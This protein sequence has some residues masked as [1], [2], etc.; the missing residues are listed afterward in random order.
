M[1]VGP[2]RWQPQ[3]QTLELLRD[4]RRVVPFAGAGLG[5]PAGLPSGPGLAQ[6]LRTE[7]PLAAGKVFDVPNNLISVSSTL[8]QNPEARASVAEYIC[9]IL[10]I[11]K[12]GYTP[13]P[14]LDH[15]VRIPSRWYV[16]TTYD[17]LA[18]EAADGQGIAYESFTW[19]QLPAFEDLDRDADH[20]LYIVHLHGS[21]MEPDSL[22][23][24]AQSYHDIS[25]APDVQDF[26]HLL[27][28]EFHICFFGT[29]LDEQYLAGY[30]LS[31]KHTRPRHVLVGDETAIAGATEGRAPI[32]P[33]MHGVM[34]EAFPAGQ[35]ELLDEFCDSLVT[36]PATTDAPLVTSPPPTA[37]DAETATATLDLG[38]VRY[39]RSDWGPD[40]TRRAITELAA[41]NPE[42]A[43]KLQ[44]TLGQSDDRKLVGVLIREPEKWMLDGSFRL[45]V[46]VTRF[47]EQQGDW[48]LAREGWLQAAEREGADKVACLVAASVS[49]DIAGN[50]ETG[51]ALLDAARAID[52]THPRVRLQDAS[53]AEDGD[54]QLRALEELW[55]EDGD[56]GAI[57]H[58]QAAIAYLSRGEFDEAESHLQAARRV[59]VD[60]LQAR[61]V[62]AN[63][64]VHRNRVALAKGVQVDGR[65]LADVRVE[66]LALRDELKAMHRWGESVRLLMLAA[67]ATA[68]QWELEE[69]GRL[70]L[71]ATDEEKKVE[72]G[73]IVLADAALRA[74]QS[75]VALELLGPLPEGEV[76]AMRA[77]A[78]LDIGDPDV[79][80]RALKTLDELVAPGVEVEEVELYR[81]AMVR[82][83][84]ASQFPDAGWPEDAERVLDEQG[85]AEVALVS[86]AMWLHASGKPAEARALL[87]PHAQSLHV[88]ELLLQLAV[89]DQ[90]MQE[91]Q[92]RVTD[93]LALGPDNLTRLRCAAVLWDARDVSRAKA[94]AAAVAGDVTATP[95]ERGQAYNLLAGIAADAE[96][97]YEQALSFFE[98]WKREEPNNE[99]HVWGRV[100]A[101]TRLARHADAL[102]L[103]EQTRAYPQTMTDGRLAAMVYARM[104]DPVEALRR[105][106]EVIDRAPVHD[107]EIERQLQ[108]VALHR[109]SGIELP[110]ELAA[111]V[112]PKDLEAL[113]L[114]AV[115]FGTLREQALQ[116]QATQ[117]ELLRGI[118]DGEVST[119]ALAAVVGQDIGSL[120]MRLSLRPLGYGNS[121][122]DALDRR[123]AEAALSRG[124][125]LDPTALFTLGGLGGDIGEAG[126]TALSGRSRLAQASLDD[127]DHGRAALLAELPTMS[128]RELTFDPETGQPVSIEWPRELVEQ[129]HARA[130]E[131]LSM[132]R[133]FTVEP[134]FDLAHPAPTDALVDE[135]TSSALKSLV[136]TVSVAQRTGLPIYSDDRNVRLLVR[137][138]RIPT[139]GTLVLLHALQER[140]DL[141]EAAVT[142]A[143]QRLRESGY[144]GVTATQSELIELL[145]A[146]GGDAS[147][148]L[149]LAFYD[150][151]PWRGEYGIHI[152]RVVDFLR[153]VFVSYPSQFDVWVL[154]LLVAMDDGLQIR[155]PETNTIPTLPERLEWH[156][157]WL[158]VAA[159]LGVDVNGPSSH[160]FLKA[161]R[162]GLDHA[163]RS[164]D[165][166]IAPLP[167]AVARF[168]AVARHAGINHPSG[169][170]IGLL[171]Q[172]PIT[173]VMRIVGV[174]PEARFTPLPPRDTR[175][176]SPDVADSIQRINTKAD[177]SAEQRRRR[178]K[179]K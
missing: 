1:A 171:A 125:V 133:A 123:D 118:M 157:Q 91:A 50:T 93:V 67:D 164:L 126:M 38:H 148:A 44:E 112:R 103:L 88:A 51:R 35:F 24:D 25:Q 146:S 41:N 89:M 48:D 142:T 82:A 72:A 20:P 167:G 71:T 128:R 84:R 53:Q 5:I 29:A 61:I 34:T 135:A 79:K 85:H 23:L 37:A 30:L 121:D 21:V 101:L 155:R 110:E 90:D 6:K 13:P 131:M 45:W 173:D 68:L 9:D 104:D 144:M 57:A 2:E 113:R 102:T 161:L 122:V 163:A 70:L 11:D 177:R 134:D 124:A 175:G 65:A 33:Q 136:A 81:A 114:Q 179:R 52:A 120:W 74:H 47:A 63:L 168:D 62:A 119:M 32:S 95:G 26:L 178:R 138:L 58:A 42:E 147:E 55:G 83:T 39:V 162:D 69:A 3:P 108:L 172:M 56:V 18:E 140:G 92:R 4:S 129:D 153:R 159:W 106:S 16:T 43:L 100:L 54:G 116:R 151:A 105:I 170:P 66:C 169:I 166:R 12:H 98:D 64:V 78:E 109:A 27:F 22:I 107:E 28:F 176:P 40:W 132:A 160:D 150:P 46:A 141:S 117:Q 86:K 49:A 174:D 152:V 59:R 87:Q 156:A 130:E 154:R 17:V 149:R 75:A 14:A 31:W 10:D 111:R 158:L 96:R 115:S 7:H 127:L 143:C 145:D 36:R 139:F 97:D 73:R 19:Q 15:L 94:E 99:R 60:L 8:A 76:R 77:T 165:T 137:G 80:Q